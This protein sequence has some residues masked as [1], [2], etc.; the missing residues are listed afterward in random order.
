MTPGMSSWVGHSQSSWV[1]SACASW[2][3]RAC[4]IHIV[5]FMTDLQSTLFDTGYSWPCFISDS[6]TKFGDTHHTFPKPKQKLLASLK[7]GIRKTSQELRMLSS[8]NLNCQVRKIARNSDSKQR[9]PPIHPADLGL[10]GKFIISSPK[11]WKIICL[12]WSNMPDKHWIVFAL[13]KLRT[14]DPHSPTV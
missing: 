7:E 6:I 12:E 3:L 2:S 1:F 4:Y 10:S 5:H 11:S 8:V 9:T 13:N 14:L